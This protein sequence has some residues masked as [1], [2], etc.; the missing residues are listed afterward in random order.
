MA[1]IALDGSPA[2]ADTVRIWKIGSP[3][4][5]DTPTQTI[6]VSLEE[7]ARKLGA[8]VSVETFPAKGF[9]T[10][11]REA[12]LRNDAPDVLS[13]DNF[14]V[15][16]GITTPLGTFEG[17]SDASSI[18]RNFIRVT[19]ALDD[20][21]GPERGWNFLLPA[22]ANHDTA[23][24]L[25]LRLP[26]CPPRR[27][28][29]LSADLVEIV[30]RV[31]AAYVEGNAMA[32][33]LWSDPDRLVTTPSK[34]ESTSVASTQSCGSFGNDRFVIAQVTAAYKAESSIGQTLVLLV[35]R[36]PSSVWQLLAASRDPISNA[37]FWQQAPFRTSSLVITGSESAPSPPATLV[38]PGDGDFP[39]P[40]PGERFG[41][42]EWDSSPS[43]DIVT[44][45]IEFAY[46]DDARLFFEADRTPETRH[47]ISSGQLWST[48]SMWS[49]RVWSVSQSG[50]VTV[51][52]SRRF[53]H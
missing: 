18:Q 53:L 22:S 38:A 31:A 7:S 39:S 27:G 46:E 26:R 16:V 36:K 25:A 11:F 52:A 28:R 9:A 3:Y 51:S 4:R 2:L 24:A 23:R 34:P 14:G 5:G 37:D 30:P 33:Q 40:P 42:F 29:P 47:Q 19:G 15:M 43:G 45:I 12:V 21:L 41:T 32:L 6:P 35:L 13:F 50:D 44:H 1:L 8:G 48:R 20:L 17:I 49:W 10:T